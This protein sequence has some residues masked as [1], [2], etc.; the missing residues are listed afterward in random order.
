LSSKLIKVTA[1][2]SSAIKETS[3]LPEKITKSLFTLPKEVNSN[4]SDKSTAKFN[5]SPLQL[6]YLITR[7]YLVMIMVELLLLTWMELIRL[8]SIL[9]IVMENH[10]VLRLF[11]SLEL[12]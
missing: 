4:L 10:G 5:I 3:F 7:L 12:S 2:L 6:M 9:H 8:L 1:Q 11:K